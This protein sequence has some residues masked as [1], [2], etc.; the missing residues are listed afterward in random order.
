ME[1]HDQLEDQVHMVVGRF[2]FRPA[3]PDHQMF[4]EPVT[5][6]FGRFKRPPSS[7]A[8]STTSETPEASKDSSSPEEN[9]PEE[10]ER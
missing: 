1:N 2:K 10:N 7:S 9:S 8:K 6:S 4:R 3:P 5:V